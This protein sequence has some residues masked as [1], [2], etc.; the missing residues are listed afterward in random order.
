[1]IALSSSLVT[2][3]R[4]FD[5]RDV[6]WIEQL[7]DLVERTIDQPWRVL[8]ERVDHAAFAVDR[9]PV[10]SRMRQQVLHA[11]RR[12]LGG[13][14]E[15]IRIARRLRA[16]VLGHPALAPGAREARIG[17]AAAQIGIEPADVETLLWADLARERPVVLPKGRPNA[18]SLAAFANVD[19]IQ[20][21][22]RRAREIELRVWGEAHD[23]VRLAARCGLITSASCEDDCLVLRISGPLSLFH[24]TSVY[25]RAL[26]LLVPLLADHDRFEL[27]IHCDFASGPR[28]LRV[29][30]PVLLPPYQPRYKPSVAE[31]LAHALEKAEYQIDREPPPIVTGDRV[32]FPDFAIDYRRQR[33]LVE[34]VGFS[35]ADY[36]ADKLAIYRDAKQRIVLCV[37]V[38]RSKLVDVHPN[39]VPFQRKVA[40]DAITN[41]LEEAG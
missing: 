27:D 30:P 4:L 1:V 35:T 2:E 16:S 40:V 31:R 7:L 13:R 34:V 39:V 17:E 10:S 32:L 14:A 19:R 41:I 24:S 5:D 11:L 6:P 25:G 12:I 20:A 3:L 28:T 22:V 21:E 26:A 29:I 38:A 15:R 33:W 9:R 8:Q 18:R 36:L 23:L 37:D